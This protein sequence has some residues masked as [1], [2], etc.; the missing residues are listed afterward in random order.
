MK[1]IDRFIRNRR[2]QQARR[3]IPSGSRVLDIGC[4]DG[5]FFK[6]L[7]PCLRYGVGIDPGLRCPINHPAFE[8]LPGTFPSDLPSDF[9][10]FDC[11]CA[12]AVLEHIPPDQTQAFAVAVAELLRADGLAV[13]TVPSARVDAIL[14][15]L[16]RLKLVDGMEAEQHHEFDVAEV[17]PLFQKTGLT[18]ERHRRFQLGLNNLYVFRKSAY[19]G[20]RTPT[21]ECATS[22]P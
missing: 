22:L 10:S 12:L 13:L 4:H 18:L 14:A 9:R 11:V 6:A 2:I 1:R 15:V 21:S 19:S 3:A 16:I 5:A 8:L 20:L 7:G 17:I